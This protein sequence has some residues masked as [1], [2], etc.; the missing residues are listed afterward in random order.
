[1]KALNTITGSWSNE[2][3]GWVSETLQL[4]GDTWLEI[5]LQQ[6]GRVVIK[7]AKELEGPYP[8]AMITKW[9]GPQFRIK[10][11]G[12]TKARYV[13]IIT[14]IEPTRIEYVNI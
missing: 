9:G 12:T 5:D 2:A 10:M 11:Y 3:N 8:K 14:T 6:E 4:T 13:K 1:M 7:K